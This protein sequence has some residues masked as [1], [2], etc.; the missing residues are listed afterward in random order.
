MFGAG[1]KWT[2]RVQ[3]RVGSAAA[4]DFWRSG[5]LIYLQGSNEGWV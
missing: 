3:V 4:G 5:D 2:V 1:I